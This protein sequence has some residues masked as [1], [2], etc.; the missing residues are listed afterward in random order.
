MTIATTTA[1]LKVEEKPNRCI[2]NTFFP[3]RFG[4]TRTKEENHCA[5]I[6]ARN[7]VKCSFS[8]TN[9]KSF[10]VVLIVYAQERLV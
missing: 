4:H 3:E 7:R 2:E 8:H 10:H 9:K 6:D 1:K 5:D